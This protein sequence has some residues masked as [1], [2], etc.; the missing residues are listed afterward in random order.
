MRNFLFLVFL[1]LPLFAFSAEQAIKKLVFIGDSLTEGYGVAK[2]NAFPA[3]IE[4]KLAGKNWKVINAG[5]SGSTSASAFPSMQWQL[6]AKPDLIVLALGANDALRALK[7]EETEKNLAVALELAQKEKVPVILAGMLAPPNYGKDYGNHFR[8]IFKDLSK[9]YKTT[10][11]PFLLVN[12]AGKKEL[13]QSDGIH[14]NEKGHAIVADTVW[15][16]V[17]PFVEKAP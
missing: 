9:K 2:E 13:N 5:M 11:I 10:L 8:Q 7:V 3:L 1:F 15:K 6:K 12:V 17:Q 16:A 4:K 14:P